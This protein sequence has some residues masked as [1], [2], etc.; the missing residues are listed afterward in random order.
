MPAI[1][2]DEKQIADVVA[3]LHALLTVSD[4][5]SAGRPTRDYSLKRLLTGNAEAGKAYF[6]GKG[7]CTSCHSV[8]GDLA[9][10]AR[11]YAPVE[12]Q[13]RF[14]YP[15]G[16][17]TVA[18]VTLR[19][20]EAVTGKLVHQDAFYVAIEDKQG[21]YHSWASSDVKVKL[22]DPLKAHQELLARYSDADVHNLFAFLE[23]LQ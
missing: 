17:P 6:N 12:L 5:T 1:P 16:K 21:R 4:R 2:L 20:G 14:L 23:T 11:R 10:V 9:G 15:T 19:S 7:G 13:T 18:N 3:Y 8:T 22:D